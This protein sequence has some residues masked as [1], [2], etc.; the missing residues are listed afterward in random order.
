MK[1]E[2]IAAMIG[3]D[4]RLV[5]E[6]NPALLRGQT[7][8]GQSAFRINIPAGRDLLLAKA[9]SQKPAIV[10]TPKEQDADQ[11]ITHQ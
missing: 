3:S 9:P 6:L 10:E 5:R 4:L 2:S 11:L 8:P 1:L 7:P